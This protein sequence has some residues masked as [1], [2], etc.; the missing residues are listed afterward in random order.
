[1]LVVIALVFIKQLFINKNDLAALVTLR[2][3]T[4]IKFIDKRTADIMSLANA[5]GGLTVTATR[6]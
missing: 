6:K 2:S 5:V 3:K 1:M 4:I